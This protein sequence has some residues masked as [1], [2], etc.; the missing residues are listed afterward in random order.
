VKAFPR[1]DSNDSLARWIFSHWA[2][3]NLMWSNDYPHP[4]AT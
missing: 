1:A 2:S 4:N 3:N